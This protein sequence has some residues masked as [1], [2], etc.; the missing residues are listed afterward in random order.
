V[1]LPPLH[2]FLDKGDVY[3]GLYLKEELSL[4]NSLSIVSID[5][6]DE[7]RLNELFDLSLDSRDDAGVDAR[8]DVGVDARDDWLDGNCHPLLAAVSCK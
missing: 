7:L 8:D 1:F 3:W 2:R 5:V 4:L 6:V